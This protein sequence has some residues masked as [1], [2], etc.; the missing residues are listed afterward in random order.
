MKNFL[1]RNYKP[2][3]HTLEKISKNVRKLLAPNPSPFTFHGTGTYIVGIEEI[4]IIDPGPKVESHIRNLLNQ[5]NKRS[6]KH[7][8]ITHTHSDHSPAAEILKQE[9]G[10]KTYGFGPYPGMKTNNDFEEGHDTRFIPDIFLEDG[11]EVEA[12]GWTIKA[13]HTPGHTSNHM[14]Y[15][16][17]EDKILFTG[18][19]VMGWATTVIVPPDGDMTEYIKSLEKIKKSNL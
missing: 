19:H 13:I 16:L 6:I 17:E 14:C 8:F 11:Q 9:T 15:G 3:Y 4:C 5:I 1:N 18:D 2:N 10:A 12:D 7:I